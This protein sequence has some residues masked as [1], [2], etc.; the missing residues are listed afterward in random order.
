[1]LKRTPWQPT[2]PRRQCGC[3]GRRGRAATR[4]GGARLENE[5]LTTSLSR[6]RPA[7]GA[8]SADGLRQRRAAALADAG[9]S[10]ARTSA[11]TSLA[12]ASRSMV[13]KKRRKPER[14]APA[15][16]AS[17]AEARPRSC[18]CAGQGIQ[19]SKRLRTL[20]GRGS[21]LPATEAN[22]SRN[23]ESV[24]GARRALA[25]AGRKASSAWPTRERA[26]SA[27]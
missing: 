18:V 19:D 26:L 12:I 9:R 1:M 21:S 2:R 4:C 20:A 14:S 7:L 24:E 23:E 27:V 5:A 11:A 25:S 17:S 22:P 15:S 3:D 10:F 16:C 6:L 13:A 8:S